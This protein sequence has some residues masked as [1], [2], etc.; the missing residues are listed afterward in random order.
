MIY[1]LIRRGWRFFHCDECGN[2]WKLAARDCSSLSGENC[3][4]C[5]EWTTPHRYKVDPTIP[6]DKWGNLV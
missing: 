2:Q 4:Q 3:P 1:K 6:V 5:G